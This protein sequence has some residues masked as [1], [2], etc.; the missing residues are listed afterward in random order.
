LYLEV[1]VE[2]VLQ[3]AKV[4]TESNRKKENHKTV[5]LKHSEDTKG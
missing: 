3:M 4:V 1:S 5:L 2:D